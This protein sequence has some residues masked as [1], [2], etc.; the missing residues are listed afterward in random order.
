MPADLLGARERTL[1]IFRAEE[2]GEAAEDPWPV[3]VGLPISSASLPPYGLVE[4]LLGG[5]SRAVW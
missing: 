5:S 1:G 4:T 2:K 3:L